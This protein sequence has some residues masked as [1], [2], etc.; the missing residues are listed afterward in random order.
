MSWLYASS[1]I[2]K[3]LLVVCLAIVLVLTQ[4]MRMHVHVYDDHASTDH[5][6]QEKVHSAYEADEVHPDRLVEIDLTY[7]GVLNNLS[8][9][10]LFIAVFMVVALV[11]SSRQRT[12]IPWRWSGHLP[13]SPWRAS[14]PPPLRAPPL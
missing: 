4:G 1:L 9:G 8:F 12:R 14:L 2:R 10:S 13:F 5:M 3:T 11:L 6:H 7:Q